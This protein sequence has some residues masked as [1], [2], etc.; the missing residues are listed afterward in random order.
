VPVD[1][2][3]S[4]HDIVAGTGLS[5]R[6]VRRR[7]RAEGWRTRPLRTGRRGRPELGYL[8]ADVLASF[9]ASVDPADPK[10]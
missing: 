3:A 7:A 9:G 6:A 1:E 10:G 5:A 2:Y 8:F 4:V